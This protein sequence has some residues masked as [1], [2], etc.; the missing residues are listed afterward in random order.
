MKTL[1]TIT[2]LLVSILGFSQNKHIAKGK[3]RGKST[4]VYDGKDI[5]LQK[6]N[7][8]KKYDE[9]A[10]NELTWGYPVPSD[11]FI[12]CIMLINTITTMTRMTFMS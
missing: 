7:C 3:A 12:V 1:I 8:L 5:E 10:F 9:N 4:I 6:K 2:L 11:L